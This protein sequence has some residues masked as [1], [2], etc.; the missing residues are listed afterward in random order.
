MN[1]HAT[2]APVLALDA[3]PVKKEYVLLSMLVVLV[4]YLGALI[5]AY[6]DMLVQRVALIL[7]M[8]FHLVLVC[9]TDMTT[10]IARFFQCLPGDFADPGR[11]RRRNCGGI[12]KDFDFKSRRRV[13]RRE[14][15]RL[16]QVREVCV[17]VGGT[18]GVTVPPN[19][20]HI[21]ARITWT[22]ECI[23]ICLLNL[24]ECVNV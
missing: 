22:V 16:E 24:F 1:E 13:L 4:V 2:V 15:R 5:E 6:Q 7:A 9:V 19:K 21:P 23:R 14:R 20:M 3:T 8:F 18:R 12:E 11:F 17:D 10:T